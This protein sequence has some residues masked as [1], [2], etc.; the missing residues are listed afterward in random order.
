MQLYLAKPGGQKIGPFTLD[1]INRGLANKKYR[2]DEYWAWH[3]GLTEWT[4]LHMVPGISAKA[5]LTLL[6]ADAA[7]AKMSP[8]TTSLP[9]KSPGVVTTIAPAPDDLEHVFKNKD[10]IP[11]AGSSAPVQSSKPDDLF[12]RASV[13]VNK[14][15]TGTTP[16]PQPEESGT[17]FKNAQPARPEPVPATADE[18]FQST[19]SK[20]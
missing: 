10:A 2:E 12:K 19:I 15:S 14:G 7:K 3:D 1:Q 16:A 13:T 18:I 17:V 9:V 4:P 20:S 5:G 6:A 8:K 11:G